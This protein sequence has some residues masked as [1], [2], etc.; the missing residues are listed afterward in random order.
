MMWNVNRNKI[1]RQRRSVKNPWIYFLPWIQ[2]HLKW[3][4]LIQ[5]KCSIPLIGDHIYSIV[6]ISSTR[7]IMCRMYGRLHWRKL[8]C[9]N[10]HKYDSPRRNFPAIF[11]QKKEKITKFK[12]HSHRL[13]AINLQDNEKIVCFHHQIA[14]W[15]AKA[16]HTEVPGM[17][18]RCS[19]AYNRQS[20]YMRYL[21]A[22]QDILC[23]WPST[24]FC[25]T[26]IWWTVS[27]LKMKIMIHINQERDWGQYISNI[28]ITTAPTTTRFSVYWCDTKESN[29]CHE[30]CCSRFRIASSLQIKFN[31]I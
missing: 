1:E 19:K 16:T 20:F 14:V 24:H 2:V 6:N 3:K 18:H 22:M 29:G 5:P 26:V 25:M 10:T 9:V 4:S 11:F 31:F 7:L 17:D 23:M 13:C 27:E 30:I 12:T 28:N 15:S 21:D 8:G